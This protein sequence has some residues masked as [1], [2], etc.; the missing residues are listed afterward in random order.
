MTPAAETLTK[1]P[2]QN[3]PMMRFL[4]LAALAVFLM[5][6][7]ATHAEEATMYGVSRA[8]LSEHPGT[9]RDRLAMPRCG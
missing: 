9:F 6:G 8:P 5:T 7:G 3:R 1:G 4:L 2:E